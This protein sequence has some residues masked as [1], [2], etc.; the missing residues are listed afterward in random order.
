[1]TTRRFAILFAFMALAAPW[2]APLAPARAQPFE[3]LLPFLVDLDGW[4][5]EKPDGESMNL[6]DD[7]MSRATREYRRGDDKIRLSVLVGAAARSAIGPIEIGLTRETADGHVRATTIG[8]F[9]ALKIYNDKKKSG[10][11]LIALDGETVVSFSY[12]GI[13]EDE[14]AALA[15]KLDLNGVAAAAKAK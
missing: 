6:G 2:L 4:Q 5:G 9:K 10:A 11:V 8:G 12:E 1:M 15:E 14:A 3:R 13:G 7:S